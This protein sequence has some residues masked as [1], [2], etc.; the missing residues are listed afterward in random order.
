MSG[1]SRESIKPGTRV[2]I[3]QKQDQRNGK[4]TGGVVETIL[5]SSGTHPHG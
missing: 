1:N 3:V 4:L 5:T 2:M